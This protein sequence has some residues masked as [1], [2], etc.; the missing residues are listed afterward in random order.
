MQNEKTSESAKQILQAKI[1]RYQDR[2]K[3]IENKEKQKEE[4][5][6]AQVKDDFFKML[7]VLGLTSVPVEKMEAFLKAHKAEI[8]GLPSPEKSA[9][10]LEDAQS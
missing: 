2:L 10:N 6:L 4:K 1:K 8:I 5:K 3:S 9:K 7:T